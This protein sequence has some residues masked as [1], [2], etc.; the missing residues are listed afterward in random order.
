LAPEDDSFVYRTR[1]P[2]QKIDPAVRRMVLGAGGLSLLVIV[3]ALLWSGARGIGFGPPPVILPPAGPLRVAPVDPGGLTVPEADVQI[4]S[5][6]SETLPAALAPAP[7]APALSQ[8]NQAAGVTAPA[9]AA[10]APPP[11]PVASGPAEVQLAA[12]AD[13]PGALADWNHL[14]GEIPALLGSKNPEILPAVVNGQ[15]QWLLRLSGFP[16]PAAAAAFCASAV[17]KGV[18]CTV[19]GH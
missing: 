7:A 2:E 5:G 13:E 14:K 11:A 19:V 12:A 17:A 18:P 16:D 4:M 1:R 10:P 3:V 9:P 6:D 8:L 15:S